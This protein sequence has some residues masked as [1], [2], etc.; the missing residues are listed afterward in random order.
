[1]S[2]ERTGIVTFKGGPITLV[3]PEIKVGDKAPE[4]TAIESFPASKAIL[5]ASAGK[6]RIIS[7]VPSLDTGICSIQTKKF[8]EE[9]ASLPDNVVI[10]TI[11]L[12]LPFAQ[13]RFC[14]AEGTSKVVPLSDFK[15]RSFGEAYGVVMKELGLLARAVFVVGPDDVVKYVQIVPEMINEPDYAAA[16]AAAK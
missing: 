6:T 15:D 13:K 14:T 4:F 10:Y 8:N 5:A 3:G 1:M 9:A 11:S 12:D 2:Q 16:L 7:V